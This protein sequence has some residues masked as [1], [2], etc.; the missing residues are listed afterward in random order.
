MCGRFTLK[1]KPD[2][3]SKL[4]PLLF[5]KIELPPL[6]PRYNVAP[7]QNVLA[8]RL[9]PATKQPEAV[10]LR[11]GLLP[12]WAKDFRIG[13]QLIN[14]RVETVQTK[15]AFR[16]AFK[17][18]H[19][20]ILADGF[21]QWHATGAKQKQPYYIHLPEGQ[22][23]AF[24]GLWERWGEGDAKIETCTI[25]TTEAQGTIK[26]LHNRMPVTVAPEK[27][28]AWLAAISA[29]ALLPPCH[30]SE[31]IATPVSTRVN[32]PRNNDPACIAPL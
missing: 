30:A 17:D 8:V 4:F 28:S 27:Y 12:S 13:S 19:C 22:P 16:S 7:T 24:A 1:T 3:L 32:S 29:S 5:D 31:W 10:N 11:W 14:A 26:S 6:E 15:P 18:R 25:L 20:L 2:E 9:H 23:F 21:Y